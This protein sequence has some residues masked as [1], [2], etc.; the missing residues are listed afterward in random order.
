MSHTLLTCTLPGRVPYARALDMQRRLARMRIDGD[1]AEDVLLLLEHE[2]VVTLGRG[3]RDSSVIARGLLAERGIEVVEIERGGDVTYHGPGQ[4]VGY[5]IVDLKRYR[6]DLHWYVRML[7]EAL[8]RA[9]EDLGLDA[10][11]A[12]GLTG[13]WVGET[14]DAASL[15][16][17]VA[18]GAA[19]KI[20]SIGVHVSRWVT[21][22]GLALNVTREPLDNFQLIVPCGIDGV[23]MTCIE[24][25]G[26]EAGFAEAGS[27]VRHGFEQAF[28]AELVSLTPDDLSEML[29]GVRL[30]STAAGRRR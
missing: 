7:E 3:A 22:H 9:L 8:I 4:L 1:L 10:F 13:V 29:G 2:P 6:T 23:R 20:A 16:G 28:E 15:P 27:S 18:A 25:E 26:V 19:R 24:A 17:R 30:G 5:P 14:G 12:P 21:W 11:R